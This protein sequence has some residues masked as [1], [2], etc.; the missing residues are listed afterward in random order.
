MLGS[1]KEA[2]RFK[3]KN[4]DNTFGAWA[5][6]AGVVKPVVLAAWK[7]EGPQ[8]ALAAHEPLHELAEV[9]WDHELSPTLRRE[10]LPRVAA[11]LVFGWPSYLTDEFHAMRSLRF[12]QRFA[13]GVESL[14]F[15]KL[16]GHKPR[17]RVAGGSGW[18]ADT[19]AEHA[20]GL[21]LAC[22][23]RVAQQDAAMRRG[24]FHQ[25]D[26]LSQDL[27]GKTL[28]VLGYGAIGQRVAR[29][30]RAFGMRVVAIRRR[31]PKR[32]PV[33]GGL[34]AVERLL[35]QSDVVVVALPLSGETEGL[36]DA[37]RLQTMKTGSILVN[38]ARGRIID[39]AA[40]YHRLTLHADFYAG[41][42]VWWDYPKPGEAFRLRSPFGELPNVV[43]TPHVAALTPGWR[44]RAVS[45]GARNL[46]TFLRGGEP[47]NLVD[48]RDYV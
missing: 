40:L 6:C 11:V 5:G 38:V 22:A 16:L 27:R 18:N 32:P 28:G 46:A 1:S 24:E 8:E 31:G 25:L 10:L 41:L 47:K 48:L 34:S 33:I 20:W 36:L 44:V 30:G 15:R 4:R 3:P 39:E 23:K 35:E 43:M 13:A 17:V 12:V 42:D 7:P 14:P 29:L 37:R 26:W 9:R 19:V 21:I 2:L 45:F